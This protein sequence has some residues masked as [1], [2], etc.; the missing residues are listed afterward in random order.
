M[1]PMGMVKWIEMGGAK[2]EAFY[3]YREG[4]KLTFLFKSSFC[5]LFPT[6]C[7]NTEYSFIAVDLLYGN[8]YC[9]MCSTYVYDDELDNIAKEEADKVSWITGCGKRKYFEWQPNEL[10]NNLLT[11]TPKRRKISQNSSVG[12]FLRMKFLINVHFKEWVFKEVQLL[13]E[14][15]TKG[16]L[17]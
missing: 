14:N 3:I 9:F 2:I 12:E 10:E 7:F 6:L 1:P 15:S 17:C 5:H 11:I 16:T 4:I 8:V 13:H